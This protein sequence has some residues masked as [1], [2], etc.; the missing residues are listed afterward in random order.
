MAG[1]LSRGNDLRI[2]QGIGL[3]MMTLLGVFFLLLPLIILVVFSFNDSRTVTHWTGFSL[4]WYAAVMNDG[5]LWLAVKNSLVVAIVS[6]FFTTILATMAAML[7]GKYRFRGRELFQNMLYV[8]VILPEI[9]FGVSLLALF[10]LL[11][12][13]LGIP[14]V[15]CGHITFSFPFATLIILGKVNNMPPS[16]EEASL[17]LGAN[18]MQTF[19]RVIL[20]YIS[21]GVVSGALFA[22]TLSIDDFI[23]TFF[24]AG[25]GSSTLPL[26]IYSL[27]KFGVTP[28][29]NAISTILIVFTVVALVLADR[30]Q[31]SEKIGKRVKL[32]IGGAFLAIILFLIFMPLFSK[33]DRK[34]N[35][36]NFSNYLDEGLIRDFEKQTGIDVSLDYYNDNEELLSRL[37]MGVGGYD[38][39]FPSGYMVKMLHERGLIA[40]IDLKRVPNAAYLNPLFRKLSYDTTGRYYLPYAYGY[41]AIVYNSEKIK[42]TVDSWSAMWNPA[43]RENILML[44]D[45]R[46]VFWTAYKYFGWSLDT[47]TVKLARAF[48]LLAK[49]KPLLKKYESNATFEMMLS[50]DVWIAQTWNGLIARLND[51]DPKFRLSIPKEGVIFFVDNLCIP[52]RAPHKQNA[53]RFINFL[54][55]PANAAR[56]MTG[57]KYAMPHPEGKKLL[58]PAFRDNGIIFYLPDNESTLEVIR[59]L[60]PFN[61]KLDHAWTE[62]KVN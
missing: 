47:D 29:V 23:V 61:K 16:I 40:P 50:G 2:G 21:P 25:V 46:E 7:L 53:E 24:T 35:I 39:I 6:T 1:N 18:R 5:S 13:P 51:A 9:I 36:Y 10:M 45:M 34:L 20:P 41:T 44:D 22:F 56:N 48:D 4:K 42:D 27:I 38:L 58:E 11:N 17:D 8:P 57:I 52:S 59:D 62:L 3:K 32:A 49:Q 54:L 26:K 60:G 43:Y 28:S 33:V 30:L 15:I 31:K 14:S 19:F 37:Q 55:E 12:F